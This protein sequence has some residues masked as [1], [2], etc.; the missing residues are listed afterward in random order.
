MT[1]HVRQFRPNPLP[2]VSADCGSQASA[3]AGADIMVLS[4]ANIRRSTLDC[5]GEIALAPD[6]PPG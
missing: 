1:A 6:S 2:V 5:H 4:E 3:S